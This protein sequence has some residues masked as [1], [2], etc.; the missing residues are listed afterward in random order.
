MKRHSYLSSGHSHRT[1]HN[2]IE[3]PFIHSYFPEIISF[4]VNYL[5]KLEIN[6]LFRLLLQMPTLAVVAMGKAISHK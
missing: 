1:L 3:Q 5:T 4:I 6:A 2:N